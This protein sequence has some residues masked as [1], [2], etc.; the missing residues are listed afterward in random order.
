MTAWQRRAR[1]FVG[2]SAV[3]F[4][5]F[6]ALEFKRREPPPATAP[7]VRTDPRAVVETT[8]GRIQHFVLSRENA[9]I[10]YEKQMLY[11]DGSSKL[12]G[13][14]INSEEQNGGETFTATAKEAT[15]SKDQST[16]VMNGDVK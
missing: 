3:A 11:E 6:V 4:A 5:I 9:D 14:E 1:L 10:R 16:I 8:G 15:I 2:V 12:L 7:V 13:V